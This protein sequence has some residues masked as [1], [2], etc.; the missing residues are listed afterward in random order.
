[1]APGAD[2][3]RPG[4]AG[5]APGAPYRHRARRPRRAAGPPGPAGPRQG[6]AGTA[7]SGCPRRARSGSRQGP[8][9]GRQGTGDGTL[10]WNGLEGAVVGILTLPHPGAT[11]S[12]RGSAWLSRNSAAA[13]TTIEGPAGVSLYQD[14]ARPLPTASSPSRL[15]PM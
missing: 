12:R 13:L 14:S 2:R 3:H 6:S 15:A 11:Q 4:G 10:T 9:A 7:D 8:A 5:R 1:P